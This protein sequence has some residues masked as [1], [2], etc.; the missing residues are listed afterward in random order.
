MY[1]NDASVA[2]AFEGQGINS[3]IEVYGVNSRDIDL[4]LGSHTYVEPE[5]GD[6]FGWW[7]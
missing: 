6:W 5:N 1:W 2:I 7:C 3:G 4:W